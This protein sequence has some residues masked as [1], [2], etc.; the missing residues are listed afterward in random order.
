MDRFSAINEHSMVTNP[1]EFIP[2]D[3]T[4]NDVFLVKVF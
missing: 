4:V 2:A 1:D 3:V